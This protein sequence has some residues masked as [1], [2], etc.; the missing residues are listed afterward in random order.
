MLRDEI[1]TAS[2]EA[3]KA[4][5]KIK[6]AQEKGYSIDNFDKWI[7]QNKLA[8]ES[9]IKFLK[10][11][12]YATKDLASYE[13]Y[14]KNTGKVTSA[15]ADFTKKA[16]VAVKSLAATMA[17]MAVMWAIGEVVVAGIYKYL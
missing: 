8:D 3:V 15:F 10:D 5:E 7:H 14:L 2:D 6:K 9:L 17:S 12:K 11:T 13:Q 4:F 1:P 16:S